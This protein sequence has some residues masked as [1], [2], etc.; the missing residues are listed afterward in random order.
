MEFLVADINCIRGFV[1]PSVRQSIRRSVHPLVR[2]VGQKV[3]K[4]ALPLLPTR[5]QLMA[6]YPALF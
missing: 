1:R 6:V 5:P 4:H 3:G 2:N